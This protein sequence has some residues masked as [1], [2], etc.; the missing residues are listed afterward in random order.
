M[1][2]MAIKDQEK[3]G[4]A[5]RELKAS[6]GESETELIMTMDKKKRETDKSKTETDKGAKTETDKAAKT[7]CTKKNDCARNERC[8]TKTNTCECRRG[9]RRRR[10]D[11]RCQSTF[12]WGK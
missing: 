2:M 3:Y 4:L 11:G 5:V 7:A 6:N 9:Y 12:R 8:R 1:S 10:R